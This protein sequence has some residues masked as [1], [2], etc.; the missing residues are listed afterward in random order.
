MIVR[1]VYPGGKHED[2]GMSG[3]QVPRKGDYMKGSGLVGNEVFEVRRVDW[4]VT[5]H[6]CHQVELRLIEAQPQP[7]SQV[8]E[9]LEMSIS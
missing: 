7:S 2:I 8:V 9:P 1:L 4:I 5:Q 6:G 3:N